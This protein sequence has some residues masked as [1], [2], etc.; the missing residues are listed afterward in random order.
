MGRTSIHSRIADDWPNGAEPITEPVK[1]KLCAADS[2]LSAAA[3][4]ALLVSACALWPAASTFAQERLRDD[5]RGALRQAPVD[6]AALTER[7]LVDYEI[8]SGPA[9]VELSEGRRQQS[10]VP[11]TP[12]ACY[13]VAGVADGIEDLDIVVRDERGIVGRDTSR[14]AYPVAEFCAREGSVQISVNA[15]EGSGSA[16]YGVFVEPNSREAALGDGSELENRMGHAARRALPKWAPLTEIAVADYAL[17]GIRYFEFEAPPGCYAWLA[18]ASA[19][20]SD[21]DLIV[22]RD[23]VEIGADFGL[24]TTP[25]VVECSDAPG[26]RTLRLAV[27]RGT[28]SA[29]VQGWYDAAADARERRRLRRARGP[30]SPVGTSNRA[31]AHTGE[32]TSQ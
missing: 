25:L 29:A 23:G 18:T 7:F 6:F 26:T 9:E 11:V 15:F 3:A 31:P 30:E 12:G 4:L 13:A 5:E 20:V 22:M 17:A 10:A 32:A 1:T 2:R 27:T 28:G 24:N 19:G 16:T 14:D 21:V 8:A